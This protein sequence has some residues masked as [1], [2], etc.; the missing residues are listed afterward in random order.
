MKRVIFSKI[1]LGVQSLGTRAGTIRFTETIFTPQGEDGKTFL[2]V[3]SLVK[4]SISVDEKKAESFFIMF[5]KP[6]HFKEK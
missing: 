5:L 3:Y 4:K 6:T 2:L 1:F